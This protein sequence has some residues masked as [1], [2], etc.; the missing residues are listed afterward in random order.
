VRQPLRHGSDVHRRPNRHGVRDH[1]NRR[2]LRVLDLLAR[3]ARDVLRH[4]AVGRASRTAYHQRVVHRVALALVLTTGLLGA[5]CTAGSDE[6][7]LEPT[8]VGTVGPDSGPIQRIEIRPYPEGPSETFERS[9]RTTTAG[10]VWSIKAVRHYVPFSLPDP[11][12][13]PEGCSMGG[14]LI[15]TFT[16]GAT[17]VYGPCVRPASIER[18]WAAM[19]FVVTH[20][21]CLEDCGPG[22]EPPPQLEGE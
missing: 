14:S 3:S 9:G 6:Q 11:L 21:G 17:A 4:P 1:R 15:I 19:E 13:Q 20:G 10:T 16:D 5:A 7:S 22:G 8:P 2:L 18:L 12:A